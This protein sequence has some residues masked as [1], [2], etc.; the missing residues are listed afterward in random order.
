MPMQWCANPVYHLKETKIGQK[1]SYPRGSRRAG[2]ELAKFINATHGMSSSSTTKTCAED[3][4]LCGTC[5]K[6]ELSRLKL[7]NISL[8]NIE[9]R[10]HMEIDDKTTK[11][12]STRT[13]VIAESS[14]ND[15]SLDKSSESS[16]LQTSPED[17]ESNGVADAFRRSKAKTLLDD[18]F[19]LLGLSKISDW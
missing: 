17:K 12:R 14:D 16:F 5:Y 4:L 10:K 2:Q 11:R 18:V 3:G 15:S 1:P 13:L 9:E 6:R 7:H 8:T 19:V